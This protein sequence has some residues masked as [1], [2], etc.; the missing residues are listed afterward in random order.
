[1]NIFISHSSKNSNYG[2]A[3][4][5]LLTGIG[6]PHGSI[7]FT[8]DA[9]YGIPSG[10]NIFN[11]LK[12]KI[13]EKPFVIYLL[14]PE[15]YS[16]VACLNE[17]GAAW[18][19]ESQ[20]VIMF[21]PNFDLDSD[22]F[23]NGVLD[24]REMGFFINDD[25]R[26]TH[27]VEFIRDKFQ[28][29][30]SPVLMNRKRI[31]FLR[32]VNSFPRAPLGTQ[33]QTERSAVPPSDGSDF[34]PI[35]KAALTEFVQLTAN[36]GSKGQVNSATKIKQ[37]P[38]ERFFQDLFDDKLR[39]EEILIIRYIADT[40]RYRLGVGWKQ[41]EEEDRIREWEDL[42]NL[43][44]VLSR[45]Y[46]AAISRLDIRKLTEVSETTS[47]NNPRQVRLVQEMQDRL[48]DLPDIFDERFDEVVRILLERDRNSDDDPLPF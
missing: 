5:T 24:P 39:E 27:F 43:G 23:K 33:T 13:V 29:S 6:V 42:N 36:L 12:S 14:S 11:W 28:L 48:L 30:I 25:D 46:S 20:H 17:M 2:S 21:T 10:Q 35:N 44:S 18:I 15:Y 19:I 34:H 37:T 1:M 41:K 7:T 3:L 31:E 4:V 32:E 8:S 9:V 47:S 45:R 40:A 26:L 16:S 38:D 22:G